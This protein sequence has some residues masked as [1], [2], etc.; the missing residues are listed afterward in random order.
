[1]LNTKLKKP[2][3]MVLVGNIGAGKTTFLL[4]NKQFIEQKNI[5]IVSCDAL[6]YMIG[7][8]NYCF[9]HYID[10]VVRK[11]ELNIIENFMQKK[12]NIIINDTNMTSYSRNA[13]I[14]FGNKYKYQKV[15]LI[16]D[17]LDKNT[18]VNRKMITPHIDL[19]KEE[20]GEI[21]ETFDRSYDSPTIKEGFD[22]IFY[23][24][25]IQNLMDIY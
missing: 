23:R 10:V 8:G 14:Y 24:K 12:Y 3:I 18:Y 5:I 21:W 4:H 2:F 19:G 20:W 9:H 6:R 15:A 16:F 1:M 11:S 7:G 17:Q 22:K 13:H 25:D